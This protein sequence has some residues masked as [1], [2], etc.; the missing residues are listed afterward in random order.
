MQKHECGG[1]RNHSE[2]TGYAEPHLHPFPVL[3][4]LGLKSAEKPPNINRIRESGAIFTR[5]FRPDL[6]LS[7]LRLKSGPYYRCASAESRTPRSLFLLR[8]RLTRHVMFWFSPA[9]N[10][11]RRQRQH[12][13]Y[14]PVNSLP[15]PLQPRAALI[16]PAISSENRE[17]NSIPRSHCMEATKCVSRR[18]GERSVERYRFS[19]PRKHKSPPPVARS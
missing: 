10:L 4:Q 1:S 16:K 18:R 6:K 19:D 11:S 8:D 12:R 7:K 15:E 3:Y 2:K 13:W 17:Q 14:I 5:H 9:G